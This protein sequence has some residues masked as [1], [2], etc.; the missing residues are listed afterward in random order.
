[1]SPLWLMGEAVVPGQKV[2][3]TFKKGARKLQGTALKVR[4]AV[5]TSS[6]HFVDALAKDVVDIIDEHVQTSQKAGVSELAK[7][8]EVIKAAERA[9]ADAI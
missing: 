8:S 9:H 2:G 4:E 5:S 3:G 7:T 6:V 1:M